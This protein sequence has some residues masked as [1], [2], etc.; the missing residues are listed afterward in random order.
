MT[1]PNLIARLVRHEGLRLKP[2]RDTA[3]NLTIGVG[4]NLDGAGV[5]KAE[6]LAMLASDIGAVEGALDTSQPWWRKLD[7]VRQ[8]VM[9]ELAFNLGPAGLSAFHD[10]LNAM[11]AGQYA[12]AADH[13]LASRWATQVGARASELAAL[14]RTGVA[15]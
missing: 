2:Y 12:A 6:A 3:G 5:S 7:D 11:R 4:R 13:L 1:T 9:A 15:S 10:T 8:D 14:L